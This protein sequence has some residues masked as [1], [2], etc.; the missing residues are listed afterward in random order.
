MSQGLWQSRA[1]IR[2]AASRNSRWVAGLSGRGSDNGLEPDSL[3]RAACSGY[4][5][6]PQTVSRPGNSATSIQVILS[7]KGALVRF[8]FVAF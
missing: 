8:R 1:G 2:F 6:G 3:K 7:L 5:V 4:M